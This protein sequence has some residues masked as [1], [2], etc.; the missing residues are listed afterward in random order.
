MLLHQ[1]SPLNGLPGAT[2]LILTEDPP[3]PREI[4]SATPS[5]TVAVRLL[6]KLIVLAVPTSV[7]AD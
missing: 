4:T 2:V 1:R 6:A 7:P 3:P 5:V